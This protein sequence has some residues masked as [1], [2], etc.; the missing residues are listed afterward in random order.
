MIT[1]LLLVAVLV[2]SLNVDQQFTLPPEGI[3]VY[4]FDEDLFTTKYDVSSSFSNINVYVLPQDQ[5][6]ALKSG[7]NFDYIISVSSINT[8]HAVVN[9]ET[10]RGDTTSLAV[11][12]Q[13]IASNDSTMIHAWIDIQ[14][15][16]GSE[17][18]LPLFVGVVIGGGVLVG[19]VACVVG[20]C[21]YRKHKKTWLVDSEKEPIFG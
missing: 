5:I 13:S 4:N 1:K 9:Y 19:C 8:Q 17:W 10:I 7:E 2:N 11:A 6:S 21:M 14:G 15:A 3:K 18:Q 12:I 16:S 20:W